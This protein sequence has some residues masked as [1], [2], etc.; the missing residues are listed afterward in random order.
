MRRRAVQATP[1]G[2]EMSRLAGEGR[3]AWA[4]TSCAGSVRSAQDKTQV[5]DTPAGRLESISGRWQRD[6][7]GQVGSI[8]LLGAKNSCLG[9][10]TL[11]ST[12]RSEKGP[13]RFK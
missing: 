3:A 1:N 12:G 6:P 11:E 4:E 13:R 10:G 5:K 8:E 9:G 7:A 2:L